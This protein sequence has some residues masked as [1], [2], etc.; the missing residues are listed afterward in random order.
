MLYAETAS[1]IKEL[2]AEAEQIADDGYRNRRCKIYDRM[3]LDKQCG[4][5]YQKSC[6]NKRCLPAR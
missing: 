2:G 3:L 1:A 6:N 5:A 4:N